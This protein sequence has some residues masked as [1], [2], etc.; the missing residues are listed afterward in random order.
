MKQWQNGRIR[1]NKLFFATDFYNETQLQVVNTG[2]FK[3]SFS[4]QYDKTMLT[5]VSY[6]LFFL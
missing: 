1:H 2:C 4:T 5:A 6:R 3:L